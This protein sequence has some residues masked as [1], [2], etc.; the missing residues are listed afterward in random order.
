MSN[1]PLPRGSDKVHVTLART[2]NSTIRYRVGKVDM[3]GKQSK[4]HQGAASI[5]IELALQWKWNK[6]M[7]MKVLWVSTTV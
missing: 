5:P 7:K 4:F 3:Q 6:K 2:T 1:C